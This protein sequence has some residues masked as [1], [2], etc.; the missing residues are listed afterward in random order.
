M[1]K[2]KDHDEAI[3]KRFP[4][5]Q[6]LQLCSDELK[7]V[8]S[9][10]RKSHD[11]VTRLAMPCDVQ[12]LSETCSGWCQH[13]GTTSS[14]LTPAEVA[15]Y[16]RKTECVKFLVGVGGARELW[17]SIVKDPAKLE[18][19]RPLRV[20]LSDPALLNLACKKVWL[21][22]QL[23]KRERSSVNSD[24][25]YRYDTPLLTIVS[26]RGHSL[27]GLCQA[28][29][30]N[31]GSGQLMSDALPQGVRVSFVGENAA[32]DGVRREWFDEVIKEIAHPDFGLFCTLDGGKTVQPRVDSETAMKLVAGEDYLSYFTLMGRIVGLAL[33]H[34]VT[35]NVVF[36]T[37]FIK[38]VLGMP[39]TV[40]DLKDGDPVL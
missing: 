7:E 11:K 15:A 26:R 28:L 20:L 2:A 33:F 35:L 17:E 4:D 25:G 9:T 39:V 5:L 14:Q 18:K 40:K 6:Q 23:M 16:A 8:I 32:G 19:G 27:E 10:A 38:L 24:Y 22:R 29:G 36:S 30:V 31:D 3:L 21:D 1:S 13:E 12:K 37:P 34:G